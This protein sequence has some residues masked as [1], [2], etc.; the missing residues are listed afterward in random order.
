[1]FRC[2]PFQSAPLRSFSTISAWLACLA[3]LCLNSLPAQESRASLFGQV[4][5]GSGGAVPGAIIHLVRTATNQST[6]TKSDQTGSYSVAFLAP[7]QYYLE[8]STPG[9]KTLRKEGIILQSDESTEVTLTLDIGDVA[10][11]VAVSA[12]TEKLNTSTAS[13]SYRWEPEKIKTL[14]LIGRRLTP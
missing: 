2:V 12:Q 14:P 11:Q 1:M 13:R 4:T 7:G 3:V 6:E 10:D 5:D 8:V 9:F